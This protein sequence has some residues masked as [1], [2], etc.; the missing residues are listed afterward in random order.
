[1]IT[2]YISVNYGVELKEHSGLQ[3]VRVG[4]VWYN[5]LTNNTCLI[6]GTL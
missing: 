2:T 3:E 5:L 4:D 1:M 6:N